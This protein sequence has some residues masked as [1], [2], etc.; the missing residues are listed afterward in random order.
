MRRAARGW[1]IWGG[2]LSEH[3]VHANSV[4]MCQVLVAGLVTIGHNAWD[5][6]DLLLMMSYE[7]DTIASI[8]TQI[9]RR[10]GIPVDVQRLTH[11]NMPL[12]DDDTL[13]LAYQIMDLRMILMGDMA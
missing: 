12:Q 13:L 4:V 9:E 6:R 5:G 2:S 10:T 3:G 7:D 1:K 8:K 11:E